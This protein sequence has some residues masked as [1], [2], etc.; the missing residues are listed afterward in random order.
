[1]RS[2]FDVHEMNAYRTGPVCP[3]VYPHGSARES[4]ESLEE[5]WYVP[6]DVGD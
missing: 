2:L 6:Y 4:L 5:I 1:M 3:F